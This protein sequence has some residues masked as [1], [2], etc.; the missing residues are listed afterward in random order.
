[1]AQKAVKPNNIEPRLFH[2]LLD[3][4]LFR[5]RVKDFCTG[6]RASR[7]GE[8]GGAGLKMVGECV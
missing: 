7:G 1:M 5:C 6:Q 3:V 4:G 2:V 8:G